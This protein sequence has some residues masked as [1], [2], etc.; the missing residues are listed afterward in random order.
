MN[1]QL[2]LFD[3]A[4]LLS[5]VK[6]GLPMAKRRSLQLGAVVLNYELKRARRRTIGLSI[7]DGG[8]VIAAPRWVGVAEIENVIR[9]KSRWVLNKLT[10][11]Q[12]RRR[13]LPP[14]C[15]HDGG[16]LPYLGTELILRLGSGVSEAYCS[17]NYLVLPL[18]AG[19]SAEQLRD[20]AQAWLQ[21]QAQQLFAERMAFY[22]ARAE[23][24]VGRW[25]LSTARTRWGSCSADGTIRLNWRLIHLPANVVDY[26]IAHEIAHRK[27]LN[28][29]PDFWRVVESLFPEFRAAE[30]L[31][32]R[33]PLVDWGK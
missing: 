30:A 6:P 24:A 17:D 21:Q 13:R 26:V 8:L 33:H 25:R 12:E 29:S 19:A 23:V 5:Q 32:K 1:Q 4:P 10:E 7:S 11:W 15:W 28:H 22:C 14:V 9:E 27:E 16:K 18:A 3:D 31:L 20:R 2:N